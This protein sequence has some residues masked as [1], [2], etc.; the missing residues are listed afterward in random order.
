MRWKV[1]GLYSGVKRIFG[2]TVRAIS[3]E[4][5]IQEAWRKFYEYNLMMCRA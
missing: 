3:K 5:M 2:E 1:E 4:G